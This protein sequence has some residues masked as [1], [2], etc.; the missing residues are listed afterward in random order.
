[1]NIHRA[2]HVIPEKNYNKYSAIYL[3]VDEQWWQFW[4]KDD[5][6]NAILK[7]EICLDYLDDN[8]YGEVEI[9]VE[10]AIKIIIETFGKIPDLIPD[11][12]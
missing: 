6:R 3:L 10:E 9:S 5:G 11:Y 1:M 12:S 7:T 8:S 4:R 2:I